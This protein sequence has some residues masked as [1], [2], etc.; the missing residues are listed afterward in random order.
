MKCANSRIHYDM[1]FVF[2]CL[3]IAQPHYEISEDTEPL[4]FLWGKF[5]LEQVSKNN[6]ILSNIF[7]K[8][9]GAV[10]I[11]LTPFSYDD[12]GNTCTLSYY[13]HQVTRM[14][15]LPLFR[16]RSWNISMHCVSF[17]I[18]IN[19]TLERTSGKRII[20]V[21]IDNHAYISSAN[22]GPYLLRPQRVNRNI[23]IRLT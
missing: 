23:D 19:C 2:V 10:C 22:H 13:H 20:L 17:Y 12:C 18:L 21:K 11:Q 3:H 4:K 1:M 7:H 6:S 5:C 15:H 14:T 8:I 9:Y 16:F